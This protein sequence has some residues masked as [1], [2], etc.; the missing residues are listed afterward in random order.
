MSESDEGPAVRALRDRTG[1][2]RNARH[3]S[4]AGLANAAGWG[5]ATAPRERGGQ[6]RPLVLVH[7]GTD[8]ELAVA[9]VTLGE[10]HSQRRSRLPPFYTRAVP[11]RSWGSLAPAAPRLLQPILRAAKIH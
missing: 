6:A 10:Q 5:A 9:S 2:R 11:E 7:S 3:A 4:E 8:V 1:R